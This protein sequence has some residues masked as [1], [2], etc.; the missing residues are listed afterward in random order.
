MKKTLVYWLGLIIVGLSMWALFVALLIVM[1]SSGPI[2][3]GNLSGA[4]ILTAGAI[5]F[6]FIGTRMM[7]EGREA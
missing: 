1:M 7:K 4:I 3:I 5:I 6:L 2:R